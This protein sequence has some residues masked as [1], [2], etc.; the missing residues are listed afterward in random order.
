[1]RLFWSDAATR[2]GVGPE[3]TP[4]VMRRD[5]VV[6]LEPTVPVEQRLGRDEEALPALTGDEA[7]E[8][9]DQRAVGPGEAGTFHLALEDRQLLAQGHYL[10]LPGHLVGTVARS[11]PKS[12]ATTR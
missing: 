6:R 10:G 7:R 2:Y 3:D 9:G 4:R 12:P 8:Q 11:M 1:V 5:V